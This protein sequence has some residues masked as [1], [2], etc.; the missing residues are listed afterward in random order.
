M[1]DAHSTATLAALV[2]EK[3]PAPEFALLF[4]VRNGTGVR[5]TTRYAD[6]IAMSTWPSR[7]LELQGIEIK[8]SRGDWLRE[9]KNPE[10]AEEIFR[11]C[12]RWWVVAP[13]KDIVPPAELPPRWGLM[14][15]HGNSL[16]A[17]VVAEK[18]EP[19]PVNRAFLA[20]LFRAAMNSSV[21][22]EIIERERKKAADEARRERN[23]GAEYQL[24]QANERYET[25]KRNVA[26]FEAKSGI[27]IEAWNGGRIGEAVRLLLSA[28]SD[29]ALL[30]RQRDALR[31]LVSAYEELL[32]LMGGNDG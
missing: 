5:A 29:R 14:V 19:Q 6:A 31:K 17:V 16:R 32:A 30:A 13:A 15:P 8:A 27:R 12:D 18:L 25:L 20:A 26:D 10:K 1:S 23:V 3:F 11:Y 22:A 21:P 24:R 4:E 7:G 28:A 2:R 9:K